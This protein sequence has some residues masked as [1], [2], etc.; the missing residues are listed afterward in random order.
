MKN[1][2]PLQRS[3]ITLL[4]QMNTLL[5]TLGL[6]GC[7]F[8]LIQSLILSRGCVDLPCQAA[9]CGHRTYDLGKQ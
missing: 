9:C 8:E 4:M 6:R 1:S 2:G 3:A 5:Q 7:P